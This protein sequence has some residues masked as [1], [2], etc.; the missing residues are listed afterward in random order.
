L[1]Q[2]AHPYSAA[3]MADFLLGPEGTKILGDLEYGSPL[4]PV[5][6]KNWYPETGMS[7]A[8]TTKRWNAGTKCFGKSVANNHAVT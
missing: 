1:A 4:K 3:L 6:F 8:S 2:A 5:S 7:M